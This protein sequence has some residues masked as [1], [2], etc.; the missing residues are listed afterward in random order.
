MPHDFFSVRRRDREG[1]LLTVRGN[2]WVGTSDQLALFAP[3][4]I[5]HPDV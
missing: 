1:D 5:R 3:V 2:A 4:Q